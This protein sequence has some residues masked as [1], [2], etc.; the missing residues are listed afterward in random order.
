M[1]RDGLCALALLGGCAASQ[2]A[3]NVEISGSP[4]ARL[5]RLRSP[6]ISPPI[7]SRR[8]RRPRPPCTPS[9]GTTSP[10]RRILL[11]MKADELRVHRRALREMERRERAEA[12]DGRSSIKGSSGTESA[13]MLLDR[14]GATVVLVILAF[15]ASG[16]ATPV[17]VE[18]AD[19]QS[20]HRELTGN[21]LSTGELSD[22]TQNVLRLGGIAERR[23]GRSR[24]GPGDDS[25]CRRHRVCRPERDVRLCRARLQARLGGRRAPV[26]P[27]VGGVRLRLPLPGGRG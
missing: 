11:R 3:R 10:F 2:Q 15:V 5:R 14:P 6:R 7:S 26:L 23:R 21:V 20:V 13:R 25:R 19:P 4:V 17:G 8:A 12:R 9:T 22:F 24:G 27:G 18:R 16:C 1:L